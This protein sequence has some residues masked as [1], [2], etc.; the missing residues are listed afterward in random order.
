MSQFGESKYG[1]TKF[2]RANSIN[3]IRP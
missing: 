3:E 2:V 1:I